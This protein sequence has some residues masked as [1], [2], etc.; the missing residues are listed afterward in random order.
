[1]I[2]CVLLNTNFTRPTIDPNIY[3]YYLN[4]LKRPALMPA[5]LSYFF[6]DY[7]SSSLRCLTDSIPCSSFRL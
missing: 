1:M 6:Q 5:A 4:K 2:C 7:Q 3:E